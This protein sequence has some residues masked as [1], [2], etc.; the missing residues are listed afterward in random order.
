MNKLNRL[1]HPQLDHHVKRHMDLYLK[2]GHTGRGNHTQQV[3]SKTSQDKTTLR[4]ST[5]IL[6]TYICNTKAE[7]LE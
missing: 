1:L 6:Q 7:T 3:I 2:K 5:K 4:V